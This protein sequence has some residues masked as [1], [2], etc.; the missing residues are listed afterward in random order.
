MAE[1]APYLSIVVPAYNEE[2][3][4]PQTLRQIARF[5]ATQPYTWE[6]IVVDDGSEDNTAGV[7]EALQG[8]LPHLRLIRNPHCGKGYAVRTGVLAAAGQFVFMCDADLAMPITELPKFLVA[9]RD[10]FPIAIGSREAPGARRFGEPPHRHL[11][12]RVFNYLVRLMV[13]GGI[14]DTQCGFKMF[15]RE[16]A[17]DLFQRMR[18]YATPATVRGPM[19]TGFDVEILYLARKRGYPI[20]EIPVDWYY[21]PGSKVRPLRDAFRLL[22]DALRVRWNDL[23]GCYR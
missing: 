3:R 8:E 19:V 18:L 17:R 15:R 5:L 12:G 14:Q 22:R 16:V 6:V 11:M 20:K 21:V 7:V 10:G 13:L 4:L 23:H 1:L 2:T 9:T